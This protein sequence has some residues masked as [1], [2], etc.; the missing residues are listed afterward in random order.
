MMPEAA[1]AFA[2]RS[3][4]AVSCGSV[5]TVDRPCSRRYREIIPAMSS[6]CAS[7][8][9]MAMTTPSETPFIVPP[10]PFACDEANSSG[11]D[12]ADMRHRIT[13]GS[14]LR[15]CGAVAGGARPSRFDGNP[16]TGLHA[17]GTRK[18]RPPLYLD[19]PADLAEPGLG[20][21]IGDAEDARERPVRRRQARPALIGGR[22]LRSCQ[23]AIPLPPDLTIGRSARRTY[24]E[25][26]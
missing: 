7:V 19:R 12:K 4:I 11:P 1:I 22:Q 24:R 5:L 18:I 26:I 21:R 8:H 2:C 25:E 9:V 10:H 3:A 16:R 15:K 20:R 13:P 23:R 17:R 6:A 14:S